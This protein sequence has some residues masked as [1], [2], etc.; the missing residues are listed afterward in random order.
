MPS[1]GTESSYPRPSQLFNHSVIVSVN[2][3][4]VI[5]SLD[6]L[7]V[8]G[9]VGQEGVVNQRNSNGHMLTTA[10]HT[11]DDRYRT[12]LSASD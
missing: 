8:G 6:V 5:I 9:C 11:A 1:P 12:I 2:R 7:A 3:V 4:L 10:T